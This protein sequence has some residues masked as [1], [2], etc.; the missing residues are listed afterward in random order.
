MFEYNGKRFAASKAEFQAA[1]ET[2]H[3]YYRVNRSTRSHRVSIML[4]DVEREP[5]ALI[6][7]DGVTVTAYKFGEKGNGIMY[8]YSTTKETETFLGI[9]DMRYSVLS[10]MGREAIESLAVTA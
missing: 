5:K 9:A 6:S 3:G 8:M 7:P 2:P 1:P 4:M 10:A